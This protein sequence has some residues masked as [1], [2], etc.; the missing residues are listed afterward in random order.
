[1]VLWLFLVK[2]CDDQLTKAPDPQY[3]SRLFTVVEIRVRQVRLS[4]IGIITK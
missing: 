4:S 3:L 1:M 2:Y